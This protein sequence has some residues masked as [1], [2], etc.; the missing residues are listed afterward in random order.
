MSEIENSRVIGIEC[1]LKDE[2]FFLYSSKAP[3]TNTASLLDISVPYLLSK[4][5]TH[6]IIHSKSQITKWVVDVPDL[7]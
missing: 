1:F 5:T 3:D 7:N 4:D 6:L 2:I